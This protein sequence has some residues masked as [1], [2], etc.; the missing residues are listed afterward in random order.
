MKDAEAVAPLGSDDVCEEAGGG[1]D[2]DAG[3]SELQANVAN[4]TG[5]VISSEA[6]AKQLRRRHRKKLLKAVSFADECLLEEAA[7]QAH[8]LTLSFLG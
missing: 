7:E 6:I 1:T 4:E 8:G 2:T 3:K 5:A